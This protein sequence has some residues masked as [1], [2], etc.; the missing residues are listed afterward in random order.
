MK[1]RPHKCQKGKCESG[2]MMLNQWNDCLSRD[3]KRVECE[4]SGDTRLMG[5]VILSCIVNM[6]R[7]GLRNCV[8]VLDVTKRTEWSGATK[9][10]CVLR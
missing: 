2:V 10:G 6:P 3:V 4:W 8:E 1:S 7:E 5:F 9:A